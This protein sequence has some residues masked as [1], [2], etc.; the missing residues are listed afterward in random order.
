MTLL[1]VQPFGLEAPGGGARI[2]RGLYQDAPMPVVSVVAS[3]TPPPPSDRWHEI[4]V[5]SRPGLGPVDGSRFDHWGHALE[6][7]LAR[8]LADRIAAVGREQHAAA[9]HA[10][11]HSAAFWPA[12]LAARALEV[13]FVLNVHDDVRYLLRSAPRL[14]LALARLSYAWQAAD[15]RIVISDVLGEEYCRRYGGGPFTVV[16]D[17]LEP[18]QIS[19]PRP[20]AP[21]D[22]RVY[23]AGLFHR[24]YRPNLRDLVGGLDEMAEQGE[25]GKVALR[26][27]CGAL[28]EPLAARFPADVME[29][30]SEQ[31]VARDLEWA[32]FLYLPLMFE[33]EYHDMVAFSLS[34]KLVTYLGSGLPILYHGPPGTAAYDL[35]REHDAAIFATTPGPE[36]VRDALT[37]AA[38]ARDRVATN[39]LTL[40]RERFMLDDQRDRFWRTVADRPARAMAGAA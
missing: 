20:V 39:A 25:H 1:S 13:P 36:A 27:R 33:P 35:L 30:G 38:A 2:L 12:L 32:N 24:G 23:F 8:R 26:L 19:E 7:S 21:R 4:H 29:F 22:L 40:A 28:P 11:A 37:G 10:V 16:T 9:V 18:S 17:G 3:R 5:R 6:L 34:T 15:A 14:P 31:D